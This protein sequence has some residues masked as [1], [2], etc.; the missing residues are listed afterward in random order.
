MVGARFIKNNNVALNLKCNRNL[1]IFT[2]R[3]KSFC[4]IIVWKDAFLCYNSNSSACSSVLFPFLCN[5]GNTAKLSAPAKKL[6]LL[7]FLRLFLSLQMLNFVSYRYNVN[8]TGLTTAS[9]SNFTTNNSEKTIFHDKKNKQ[10]PLSFGSIYN[11]LCDSQ[12]IHSLARL[13]IDIGF[14]YNMCRQILNIKVFRL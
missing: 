3:L 13:L 5:A 12:L 4:N 7:N 2:T 14:V 9:H 1:C 8:L 11:I 10:S 6:I